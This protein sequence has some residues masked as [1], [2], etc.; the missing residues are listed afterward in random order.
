MATPSPVLNRRRL[1]AAAAAC[2]LAPSLSRAQNAPLFPA[3]TAVL[4]R[5]I[6]DR[7]YPGAVGAFG[8]GAAEPVF[9]SRGTLAFDSTDLVGPDTLWRAFSMTKPVVGMA[10]MI[11]I[12]EG[13]LTLDQP[14]ADLIPA[15]AKMRVLT[16]PETMASRPAE[17]PITVRHLLT[18]TGGI[19]S[20]GALPN[21][22]PPKM[23][24]A[25]R[26]ANLSA[27]PTPPDPA[28]PDL[29]Q[30]AERLATL[31]L[32]TEPGTRWNYSLS[33][34]L[35]GRVIEVA[36]G[37]AFDTFLDRRL[38][39]PLGMSSTGFTVPQSQAARLAANYQRKDD[40]MTLIDP[41]ATSAYLKPPAYP[42]GGGGLVSSA[43]DYD[44]FL[45]MIANRGTFAGRQIMSARAVDLGTSNLLPK[46]VVF[47]DM[48]S[49]GGEIGFGAA[50]SV[51]LTGPNAG[52]YG[53]GGAAGTIAYANPRTRMRLAGYINV[54]G[55]YTLFTDLPPAALK[56]FGVAAA[57]L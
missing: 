4:E 2:G 49:G 30:F 16:D 17:R 40:K 34:D 43:R 33:I 24:D 8:L 15:F 37:E 29:A 44:R 9:V 28:G 35:L 13:K 26:A 42:S 46:G 23:V 53:W 45:T 38:F 27:R 7:R 32:L 54:I 56:D 48:M 21:A 14:V 18:H 50:G 20:I 57:K 1:L 31:P 3:S 39:K 5:G 12:D 36:S 19:G 22:M 25:F 51:V 11:L 6:A 47:Q 52:Q 41:G 10:A 55:D